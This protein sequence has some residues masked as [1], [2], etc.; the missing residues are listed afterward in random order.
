MTT[1]KTI[2]AHIGGAAFRLVVDG[3]PVP[4]GQTML[5]KREWAAQHT[6]RLRRSLMLEPRGHADLC[7]AVLTEP[8]SPGAHA[9]V[10]FMHNDGFGDLSGTGIIAVTTI[11][12]ERG[13]LMPGGDG[14]T[15]VFETTAGSIRARALLTGARVVRVSYDGVPSF[16]LHGGIAV[17]LGQRQVRA[18]VAYGGAFYAIVDSESV[19]VPIDV[20]H[21]AELRRAGQEIARAIEASLTVVHP[22]DPRLH[23]IHGTIFTGPPHDSG[24][25]LRTV[26]V[27]ADRAV[28]RSAPGSGGAAV[29]SVLDAIG[30][31]GEDAPFVCEGLIG[32]RLTVRVA[33][34]TLVGDYNALV[35][36][37]EGSAWITGDH[38]FVVD[39]ADPLREGFRF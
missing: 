25:D 39:E 7:G 19:G 34:R 11:A 5:D 13:L 29:L 26:T 8:V 17:T 21:A 18:D 33:G 10:L 35:P 12:L 9:G 22:L 14:A 15:I 31:V 16:V 3:F 37:V 27:F 1:L 36:E 20:A 23:G 2:D 38:T 30:L 28:A 6:D 32:T 4:R 24:A